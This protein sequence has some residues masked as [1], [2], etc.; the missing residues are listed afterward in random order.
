MSLFTP[1][2][3]LKMLTGSTKAVFF[4]YQPINPAVIAS[5]IFNR[6]GMHSP[7]INS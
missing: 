1:P 4:L 2:A 6:G 7:K 3:I 5:L